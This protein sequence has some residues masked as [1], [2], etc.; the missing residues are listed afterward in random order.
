MAPKTL[1]THHGYQFLKARAA[2]GAPA[3]ANK[4]LAL[5]STICHY[6]VREGVMEN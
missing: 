5:M 6:A 4:E 1:T 2:G 3:W